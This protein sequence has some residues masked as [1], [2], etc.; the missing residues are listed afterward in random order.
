VKYHIATALAALT[1]A[2]CMAGA[3]GAS[4]ASSPAPASIY[5]DRIQDLLNAN[6]GPEAVTLMEKGVGA[7]DAAAEFMF[8][9]QYYL[10]TYVKADLKKALFWYRKA[11][12]QGNADAQNSLGTLYTQG[13][14]VPEDEAQAY[15][16]FERSA[17]QGNDYG[18][19]NLALIYYFSEGH[20]VPRDREHAYALLRRAAKDGDQSAKSFLAANPDL[21]A[22]SPP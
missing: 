9:E 3:L 1:F 13:Q 8:A 11:A 22:G 4:A 2:S 15:H 7:G 6:R 16:W 14:R 12:E 5:K 21:S 19:F 20:I 10:G 18:I 17:A